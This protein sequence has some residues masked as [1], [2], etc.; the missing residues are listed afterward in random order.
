M[1]EHLNCVMLLFP[2]PRRV[3]F[4]LPMPSDMQD[5]DSFIV[6][7]PVTQDIYVDLDQVSFAQHWFEFLKYELD[8]YSMFNRLL[9]WLVLR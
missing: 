8:N 4:D 5:G 9:L 7:Y 3:R 2:V 6:V 1:C